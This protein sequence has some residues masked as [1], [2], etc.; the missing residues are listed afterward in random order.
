VETVNII[1]IGHLGNG[2]DEI[3]GAGLATSFLN[4]FIFGIYVGLNGA[5]DTLISQAIGLNNVRLANQILNKANVIN[6]ILFLP[7]ALVLYYIEEI[8]LMLQVDPE[9]S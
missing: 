3:S 2:T 9:S 7:I 1:A 5:I 6:L 8:L 4:I